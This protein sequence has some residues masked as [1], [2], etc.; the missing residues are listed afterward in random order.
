MILTDIN[1]AQ[2]RHRLNRVI[3]ACIVVLTVS[4]LSISTALIYFFSDG[5]ETHFMLNLTGV[6][7][8]GGLV[9]QLLRHFRTHPYM[10]EIM[11]VW[12]LKQELNLINRRLRKVQQAAQQGNYHAMLALHFSYQGSQQLWQLDDNTITLD[13]LRPLMNELDKLAQQFNYELKT[14]AYSRDMLKEF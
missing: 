12:D 11:Y 1:K 5:S 3:I 4:A 10:H 14:D 7:L 6:V 9:L 8:G 13:D 2:Y